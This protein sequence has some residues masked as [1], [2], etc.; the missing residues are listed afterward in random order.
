METIK[1][2]LIILAL[3]FFNISAFSQQLTTIGEISQEIKTLT[4]EIS[5]LRENLQLRNN[6]IIL[7]G[8]TSVNILTEITRT[9]QSI[10]DNE[11]RKKNEK[12]SKTIEILESNIKTANEQLLLLQ[13]QFNIV[14]KLEGEIQDL[15]KQIES[16]ANSLK[17]IT[18]LPI[19]Q[20]L[21]AKLQTELM[22]SNEATKNRAIQQEEEIKRA[23]EAIEKQ[24]RQRIDYLKR[25]IALTIGNTEAWTSMTDKFELLATSAESL[26]LFDGK[27]NKK[28]WSAVKNSSLDAGIILLSILSYDNY[29]KNNNDATI[30]FAIGGFALKFIPQLFK[31]KSAKET[32]EAITRNVAFYDQIVAFKKIGSILNVKSKTLY[33]STQSDGFIP[34][35]SDLILYRDIISLLIEIQFQNLEL[36]N[37][38]E[39]LID[40]SKKN[41]HQMSSKGIEY[42]ELIKKLYDE[43][44][45]NQKTLTTIFLNRYDLL[46]DAL[47]KNEF[48]TLKN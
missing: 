44:L 14:S 2:T 9:Q 17:L 46:W 18:E 26:L 32:I 41:E 10:I 40:L 5:S 33:I 47:K 21:N 11:N 35:E 29:T 16:K 36:R 25:E 34:N 6:E 15:N 37:R 8:K 7:Q 48:Q 28:V 45:M 13:T 1:A 30:G 31:N 43:S 22:S 4:D 20:E 19:Y 38:A 12:D 23:N 3:G 24:K 39:F 27:T 42:L